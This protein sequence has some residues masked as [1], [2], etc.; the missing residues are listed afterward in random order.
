MQNHAPLEGEHL[1]AL[2]LDDVLGRLDS[3]RTGRVITDASLLDE[4]GG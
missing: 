2:T 3:T 1:D 4:N